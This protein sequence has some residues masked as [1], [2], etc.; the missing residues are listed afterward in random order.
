[1]DGAQYP[2]KRGR[3]CFI[4]YCAPFA[5]G[6]LTRILSLHQ[7]HQLIQ[8]HQREPP[9]SALTVEVTGHGNLRTLEL[10]HHFL[11]IISIQQEFQGHPHH[12]RHLVI[13]AE[14]HFALEAKHERADRHAEGALV[15]AGIDIRQAPDA[16]V[17]R[18]QGEAHFPCPC[19]LRERPYGRTRDPPP[20]RHA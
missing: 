15:R 14:F 1:M 12:L 4:G 8:H 2:I 19:G 13:G 6:H 17:R 7:V 9:D 11:A 10:P 18:T 5:H 20:A 3:P 16:L